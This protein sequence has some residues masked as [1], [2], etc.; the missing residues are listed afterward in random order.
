M[1]KCAWTLDALTFHHGSH[2]RTDTTETT[3]GP[4]RSPL[5][6]PSLRASRQPLGISSNTLH[7]RRGVRAVDATATQSE[8]STHAPQRGR[9]R[10]AAPT[11]KLGRRRSSRRA[12]GAGAG[13]RGAAALSSNPEAAARR[14]TNR[15]DAGQ[16]HGEANDYKCHYWRRL[17]RLC[18]RLVPSLVISETRDRSGSNNS[19]FTGSLT[20]PTFSGEHALVRR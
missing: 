18:R 2:Q 4:G 16:R 5:D 11:N 10:D 20:T 9:R 15:G 8:E 1:K 13:A 12:L 3:L 17:L 19:W 14:F 6:G 7:S